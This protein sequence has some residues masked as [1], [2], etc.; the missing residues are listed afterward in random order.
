MARRWHRLPDSIEGTRE[1]ACRP[2]SGAGRRFMLPL[3]LAAQPGPE[4]LQ[5]GNLRE[6]G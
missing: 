6:V 3:D 5:S 2:L 1:I 4:A